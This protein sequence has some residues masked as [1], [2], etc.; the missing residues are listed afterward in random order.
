MVILRHIS[1]WLLTRPSATR[2]KSIQETHSPLKLSVTHI[3]VLSIYFLGCAYSFS[4]VLLY[5]GVGIFDQS[6][7]RAAVT[8]CMVFDLGQ[9]YM[10]YIFLVERTHTVRATLCPRLKDVVCL[11][12]L[13]FTLLGFTT[14]VI[15]AFVF[16]MANYNTSSGLC[17]IG[18]KKPV[19]AS[20]LAWDVIVNLFLTIVFIFK[21]REFMTRG[22][23]K[24]FVPK[25]LHRWSRNPKVVKILISRTE[26]T[27]RLGISQ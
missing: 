24:N 25:A 21:V 6:G 10:L 2:I 20:L 19:V 26:S 18:L 9:K 15:T 11:L 12:G 4:L 5:Y 27:D 3:I 8:L 23:V 13:S 14:L 1:L 22:I 16:E 7:C 17:Q